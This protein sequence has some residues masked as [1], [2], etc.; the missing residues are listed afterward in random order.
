M[1]DPVAIGAFSPLDAALA[2]VATISAV[3]VPIVAVHL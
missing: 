1:L 2:V 3:V